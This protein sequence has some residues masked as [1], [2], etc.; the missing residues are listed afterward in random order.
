MSG[1]EIVEQACHHMDVMS[2]V[3]KNQHPL[4]CVAMGTRKVPPK[5]HPEHVSEHHSAAIF[6]F[7]DGV[8][9]SYTHLFY[10]PKQFTGEQLRVYGEL[11]GVDLRMGDF[12]TPENPD[13]PLNESQPDWDAGTVE[14]LK[15]FINC[16]KTG[17]KPDSNEETGR[18]ATL[19]S[20][21]ARKAMYNRSTKKFEP[22]LVRWEDL[23]STT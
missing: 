5:D 17:K 12:F 23:G 19:I 11:K 18:V 3:M 1:G 21:M 2:W 20:L 14:E 16:C 15:A 13:K 6:Q 10:C 4:C 22:T 9:Y 7:P 8:N